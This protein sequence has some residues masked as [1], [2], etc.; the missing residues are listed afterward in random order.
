MEASPTEV[1]KRV[2]QWRWLIIDE[3]SIMSARLLADMDVRLRDAVRDLDLQKRGLD[4]VTRP[5]DGL[6]VLCC[7]DFWQLD[8]PDGGFSGQ[9][10]AE[11]IRRARKYQP[12]PTVSH[13][14]ALFWGGGNVGMQGVTELI[15]VERCKDIWLRE[16]QEEFRH[17][18]LSEDNWNFLHGRPTSVPGSWAA[19]RAQCGGEA[20]QGLADAEAAPTGASAEAECATARKKLR[21]AA[22]QSQSVASRES[23]S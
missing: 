7:G 10:P 20:C 11:F 21:S 19:G 8:P 12:A 17:G 3:V 9:I 14:Q 22:P 13:G 16:V 6:I 4:S 23:G 2:L 18:C 15:E 1:A 5:F